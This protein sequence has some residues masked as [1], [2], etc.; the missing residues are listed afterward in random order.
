MGKGKS[1]QQMLLEKLIIWKKWIL[2]LTLH[3]TKINCTSITILT[4]KP[5][6]TKLLKKTKVE[7]VSWTEHKKHE[8]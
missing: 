5:K 2:T 3:Y 1:L 8:P 6:T 4:V 7:K